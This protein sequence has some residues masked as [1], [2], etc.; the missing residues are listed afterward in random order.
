MFG[1]RKADLDF[2]FSTDDR[3]RLVTEILAACMFDQDGSPLES[4]RAWNMPVSRRIECLMQ[5]GVGEPAIGAAPDRALPARRVPRAWR[6]RLAH[7]RDFKPSAPRPRS[8]IW[9][10]GAPVR[11]FCDCGGRRAAINATGGAL[12]LPTRW[13]RSA[14]CS[15]L[16]SP[17]RTALCR[18]RLR[19]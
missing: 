11:R 5:I 16:W 4:E 2:D 1:R 8:A 12:R 19:S 7:R 13:K 15:A 9:P 17:A 6:D 10:S 14:S 18:R 3:P